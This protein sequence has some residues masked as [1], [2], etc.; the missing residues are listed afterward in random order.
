MAFK[1]SNNLIYIMKND[2]I[3]DAA[4]NRMQNDLINRINEA[5]VEYATDEE[6]LK[7]ALYEIRMIAEKT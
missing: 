5:R 7:D 4:N 3:I 6:F 1:E 2:L